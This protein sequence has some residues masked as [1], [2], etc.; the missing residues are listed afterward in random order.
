LGLD[1]WSLWC[2]K[3]RG[4]TSGSQVTTSGFKVI[5]SGFK[6]IISGFKVITSG[7]QVINLEFK[8]IILGFKVIS[9]GVKVNTSGFK[10]ITSGFKA[11][12][13]GLIGSE[14]FGNLNL[15]GIS[16]KTLKLREALLNCKANK[17]IKGKFFG[18]KFL[19]WCL[20]RVPCK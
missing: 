19:A 2:G 9:L 17:W 15:C 3:R 12:T 7:S 1:F 13:S 14:N 16:R 10:V 4:H 8:V 6:V 18:T 11:H 5:T 20:L